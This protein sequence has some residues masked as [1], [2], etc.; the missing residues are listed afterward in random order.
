[1]QGSVDMGW[2]QRTLAGLGTRLGSDVS[3]GLGW[4][5]GHLSSVPVSFQQAHPGT[6]SWPQHSGKSRARG[7]VPGLPRPGLDTGTLP[8]LPHSTGHAQVQPKAGEGGGEQS[9]PLYSNCDITWQRA[10]VEE[11]MRNVWHHSCNRHP[12]YS[13]QS[14]S[15]ATLKLPLKSPTAPRPQLLPCSGRSTF[16]EASSLSQWPRRS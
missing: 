8:P 6:C 11:G 1:M 13:A 5:A 15:R 16:I 10:D 14:S 9:S 3:F 4:D 2:A 7:K 12:S